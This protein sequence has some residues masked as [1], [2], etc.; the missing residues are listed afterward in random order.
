H[1]VRDLFNGRLPLDRAFM[2]TQP[3]RMTREMILQ[4]KLGRIEL[5]YFRRKFGA[6]VLVE[7]ADTY[8]KLQD[9][10]FLVTQA[11]EIR[12]TKKGLLQV[13]QLLSEFYDPKYRNARYT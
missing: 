6:D 3:E 7:F 11:D 10:G 1:Y 4:L 5:A 12:L 2:P 9:L 13:D 8:R